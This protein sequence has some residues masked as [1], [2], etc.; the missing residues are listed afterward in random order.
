ML[1]RF[2][3]FLLLGLLLTAGCEEELGPEGPEPDEYSITTVTVPQL[4]NLGSP[5]FY[6][7]SYKVTHPD[8]PAAISGVTLTVLASD[9]TTVLQTLELFD[10][11]GNAMPSAQD[12]VAGDGV[13]TNR[14]FSDPQVFTPSDVYFRATATASGN[15]QLSTTPAASMAVENS[16]PVIANA[17]LPDSLRSGES[18][19]LSVDVTDADDLDNVSSVQVN[20]QS[21]SG[22]TLRTLQLSLQPG[23][24]TMSGTYGGVLDSSFAAERQ[25]D[26]QL[27][28]RAEDLAG[29]TSNTITTSIYLENLAPF[30]SDIQLAE[31]FQ[32]PASGLDTIVVRLSANDAQGLADI[33]LVDML[34]FRE[35]SPP[36]TTGIELFDDGDF[37]TN[38]D[39]VAGDGVYSRG[40]EI[41]STNQPGTFIFQFN[42]KDRVGNTAITI[43]DTLV[44]IAP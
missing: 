37:T 6:T 42:G 5:R 28:Y 29:A 10:D 8:G 14:V 16:A 31:T 40:L 44:T 9:Q 21:L 34:V 2:W 7:V 1:N 32:L 19:P 30:L 26:F 35:G 20:L 11:G 13:F 41:S 3:L 15:E 27:E 22:S 23:G 17:T 25:G 18:L 33:E 24:G 43:N 4:L 38:R 36:P 39:E 12:V